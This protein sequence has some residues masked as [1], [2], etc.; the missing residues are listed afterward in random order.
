MEEND[1]FTDY[2]KDM[3]KKCM[4]ELKRQNRLFYINKITNSIL[5]VPSILLPIIISVLEK[6]VSVDILNGL[7]ITTSALTS[8]MSFFKFG[9]KATNNSRYCGKFQELQLE[10]ESELI[11]K[12]VIQDVLIQKYT[13]DFNHLISTSPDC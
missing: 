12:D 9:E 8:I 5:V 10:I 2:L 7:L 11:K 3:I 4:R 1:I 13:D 6:K